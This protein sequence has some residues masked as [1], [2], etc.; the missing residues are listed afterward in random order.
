MQERQIADLAL[1]LEELLMGTCIPS[2]FKDLTCRDHPE[3]L[4][5]AAEKL[6]LRALMR[7]WKDATVQPRT[8]DSRPRDKQRAKSLRRQTKLAIKSK[9][10]QKTL[11]PESCEATQ[12]TGR[13][14]RNFT[15]GRLF[16]LSFQ[17]G[18]YL[19]L[20]RLVARLSSPSLLEVSVV[21][22]FGDFKELKAHRREPNAKDTPLG[23]VGAHGRRMLLDHTCMNRIPEKPIKFRK[24]KNCN[25]DSPSNIKL[26][27]TIIQ[28]QS[29]NNQCFR[30]L[31]VGRC[32]QQHNAKICQDTH[33][34]QA[35]QKYQ[36]STWLSLSSRSSCWLD[37]LP[38]LFTLAWLGSQ[39]SLSARWS[40]KNR[41]RIGCRGTVTACASRFEGKHEQRRTLNKDERIRCWVQLPF[42][43]GQF[44]MA[45][46]THCAYRLFYQTQ[47]FET[48]THK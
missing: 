32:L 30:Q 45:E 12:S 6:T 10:K 29:W 2:K 36:L 19:K 13:T 24:M 31:E 11:C 27:S 46:K 3:K 33:H 40:C 35:C 44:H 25:Q 43:T 26:R 18:C 47:F 16:S 41:K 15:T 7:H 42:R 4:T 48:N 14:F 9:K 28:S 1:H 22:C 39:R 20:R 38:S 34:E 37:W 23:I 21:R 5:K 8:T 17:G